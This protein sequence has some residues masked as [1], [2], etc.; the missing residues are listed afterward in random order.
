MSRTDDLFALFGKSVSR[1]PTG[2]NARLHFFGSIPFDDGTR[3]NQKEGS[4][5]GAHASHANEHHH[6]ESLTALRPTV[7]AL[8]SVNGGVGRSTLATALSSGLQRLGESV[9]ALDLDPQNALRQHFGVDHELPG[10]ARSSLLNTPW[11]TI[12]QSGFAGC[13]V[14][15]FGDADTQ[16]Q[17]N[18][19]RWL[20]R[21]PKW[22]AQRLA[23]LDL[24]ER[25]TVIVDTPAGNNVYLHQALSVA[26]IVLVVAQPNAA[27]LGTLDQLDALLAPHL[28]R[29]R[30]P[31]CHLVIN[32]LDENSAFNLDMLDAFKLRR[33]DYP[34]E[35]I[36]RDPAISEG[37]AFSTDPLDNAVTSLA[38]D[39]INDLCRLLIARKKRL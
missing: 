38:G 8:V 21:E 22:L 29:A 30:P 33:S 24:S 4:R 6:H 36:H 11:N 12:L 26:D 37:L 5:F 3:V 39:D 25:H 10:L 7:V 32:Q 15:P 34:L 35:V 18:L 19:Q 20:T 31:R 9:V 16:Q 27:C 2:K 14:I 1:D 28:E 13:Q 23:A 17:E